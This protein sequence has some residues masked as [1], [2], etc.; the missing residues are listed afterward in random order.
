MKNAVNWFEIPVVDMERALSFYNTI[1]G[2]DMQAQEP[3]PGYQAAFFPYEQGQGIGGSLTQGEGYA[4]SKSGAV[5][6]L[7]GGEDLSFV[8]DKVEENGGQIEMPKTAIGENG[9][10]AYFIDT[11][12]NKIGIHSMS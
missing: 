12:E 3:M 2:F 11:E 5:V 4:P 10:I 8:L 1:F 7:N 9:F 6:Y